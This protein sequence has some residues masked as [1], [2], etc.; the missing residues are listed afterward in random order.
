MQF[1]VAIVPRDINPRDARLTT[2]NILR[3]WVPLTEAVFRMVVK[4]VPGP[5]EAQRRRLDVL[6]TATPAGEV[7]RK[8]AAQ[9]SPEERQDIA[10]V[11]EDIACCAS[12]LNTTMRL[13]PVEVVVFIAK[14]IPARS[15]ELSARDRQMLFPANA[16]VGDEVL[17][18]IGRV[19]S[20]VLRRDSKLFILSQRHNPYDHLA[21]S[22]AESVPTPGSLHLDTLTPIPADSLGFYI[23]L[24]PSVFPTESVPAG[25][26]VG[27]VG[28][29]HADSGTKNL[30]VSKSATISSS[31]KLCPLEPMT[32]QSKPMV[33]VAVAPKTHNDLEM[34]EFGL[35]QLYAYD[36]VVE[37]E[38]DPASGQ[39]TIT[40][41]GELHL[42]QCVKSLSERFAKCEVLVSAPIVQFRETI[43]TL[44]NDVEKEEDYVR[45]GS[46]LAAGAGAEHAGRR[47]HGQGKH[48]SQKAAAAAAAATAASPLIVYN[49]IAHLPPPWSTYPELVHATA[50]AG[51]ADADVDAI[52][53]ADVAADAARPAVPAMVNGCY[54]KNF[55]TVLVPGSGGGSYGALS[56][57]VTMRCAIVQRSVLD[58]FEST[59]GELLG[60]LEQFQRA[61]AALDSARTA[62]SLELDE[63]EDEDGSAGWKHERD[64]YAPLLQEISA[65][66]RGVLHALFRSIH[67][68]GESEADP[69]GEDACSAA[70]DQRILTLLA[71]LVAFGP[72][73]AGTNMM[74]FDSQ[75]VFA[76]TSGVEPGQAQ[77]QCAHQPFLHARLQRLS[78][79]ASS[80]R[81]Q[82]LHR[83]WGALLR[84]R[85]QH[86]LLLGFHSACSGGP[87]MQEPVHGV[88]WV[89]E[90]VE[91]SGACFTGEL[92]SASA[93]AALEAWL[94]A[95]PTRG[96]KGD[97]EDDS[98]VRSMG[99]AG[100]ARQSSPVPGEDADATA[101][102]IPAPEGTI[103]AAVAPCALQSGMMI[104]EVR[105]M[106]R[107]LLLGHPMRLFEPVYR[108][109]IQCDSSVLSALYGVLAKRRS[110]IVSE[111]IIEGTSLFL[112]T[113]H[114]PV[115]ESFGFALELLKRTSGRGTNTAGSGGGG[116]AT[117]ASSNGIQ[118]PQL[119]YSH[120]QMMPQDPFWKPTTAEELE[121]HGEAAAT[122]NS[123]T[124]ARSSLD[125]LGSNVSQIISR[126][127]IDSVRVR[128]GLPVETKIVVAADKQRTFSKNK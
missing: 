64:M 85:L 109:E 4:C 29:Q 53:N 66:S 2:Q 56:M 88:A 41:L 36:P 127:I 121:M 98:S 20:G 70:A 112:L 18:G 116:G 42:E 61:Q 47:A 119:S 72:V 100:P 27:I 77:S 15:A 12:G 111:D 113:V 80:E 33:R 3:K 76:L 35:R 9:V 84:E 99:D 86:P 22:E 106:C 124:D 82:L 37:I 46:M 58:A 30:M 7:H 91:C 44:M 38:V 101:A 32:F 59:H 81:A 25:N 94:Y 43:T 71:Q 110:N 16:A 75:L 95:R 65:E 11:L 128:K 34:F 55:S 120:W 5:Q 49:P 52:S 57:H 123:S 48:T 102:V 104:S 21:A 40:C 23:C 126:R 74:L 125:P 63:N 105:E 115:I 50:T 1:N 73:S 14:M 17:M 78:A 31:V 19:F 87:L 93:A 67:P 90:R 8:A 97:L 122:F 89:I 107:C 108:C 10:R 13:A 26:I 103:L 24:G 92:P 6:V 45:A 62:G 69:D 118:A 60:V 83:L 117:N 54:R 68:A 114:L 39:H 28:L 96:P 79:A 51:G